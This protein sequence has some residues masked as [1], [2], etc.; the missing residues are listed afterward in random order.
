MIFEEFPGYGIDTIFLI[1][2]EKKE[3]EKDFNPIIRLENFCLF[4]L[5]PVASSCFTL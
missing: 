5:P 4:Q 2:S 3:S 1:L